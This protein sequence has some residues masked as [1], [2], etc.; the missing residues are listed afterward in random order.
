MK[1]YT[2]E[3]YGDDATGFRWRRK[4]PNGEIIAT[5]ESYTRARDAIRGAARANGASVEY[6]VIEPTEED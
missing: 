2:V 1:P 5:G 4:P 3:I 6:K